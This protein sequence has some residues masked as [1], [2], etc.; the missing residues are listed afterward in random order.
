MKVGGQNCPSN[1]VKGQQSPES[2]RVNQRGWAREI[3]LLFG[4]PLP[5]TSKKP[6]PEEAVREGMQLPPKALGLVPQM[7]GHSLV[8]DLSQTL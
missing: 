7:G 5:E 4:Q 3:S 1:G 8:T 6:K 2:Y